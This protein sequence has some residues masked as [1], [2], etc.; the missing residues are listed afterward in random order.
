MVYSNVGGGEILCIN[1]DQHKAH[2][3]SCTV[4]TWSLTQAWSGHGVMLTPIVSDPEVEW[5]VALYLYSN[6]CAFVACYRVNF[7]FPILN[8]CACYDILR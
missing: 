2:P 5:R 8:Y 1:S 4:G 6:L 7:T 3:A